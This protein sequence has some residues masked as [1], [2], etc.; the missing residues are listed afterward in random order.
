VVNKKLLFPRCIFF[1]DSKLV[2]GDKGESKV[3]TKVG[4]LAVK[5]VTDKHAAHL[6]NFKFPYSVKFLYIWLG[7]RGHRF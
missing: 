3:L 1:V 6:P 4:E 5:I 7:I 2:F